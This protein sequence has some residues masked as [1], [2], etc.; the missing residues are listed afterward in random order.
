MA[1]NTS[2]AR[3]HSRATAELVR[4]MVEELVIHGGTAAQA[5]KEATTIDSG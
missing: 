2:L 3:E 5:N 1:V 4:G